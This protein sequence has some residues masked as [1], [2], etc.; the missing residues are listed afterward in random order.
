MQESSDIQSY[1]MAS[2]LDFLSCLRQIVIIYTA[3]EY[4]FNQMC[5]NIY[6]FDF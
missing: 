4:I 2:K 3:W 1:F 5:S 6:F